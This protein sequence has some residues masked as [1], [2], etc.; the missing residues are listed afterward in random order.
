MPN[1]GIGYDPNR[2][3]SSPSMTPAF[4]PSANPE[5]DPSKVYDTPAFRQAASNRAPTGPSASPSADINLTAQNNPQLDALMSRYTSWMDNL[6]GG[7]SRAMD[8]VGSKLRDAREGGRRALREGETL[9]GVGSSPAMGEYEAQTQQGVRSGLTD[10]ALGREAMMGDAIRGGLG[11][12][13]AGP[14]LAL[15]ERQ[16]ALQ[17]QA[18]AQAAQQQ[19][20]DRW[21]ALLNAQ[22]NSPLNQST[23]TGVGY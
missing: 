2:R 22:R 8:I 13:T 10:L 7:T 19:N 5:Y 20:F 14:D 18:A 1:L 11:L 23:Y 3:R 6:E 15:R 16:L 9:R 17:A 4:V 12:A 21:F